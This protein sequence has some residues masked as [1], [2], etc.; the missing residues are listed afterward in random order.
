MVQW[1]CVA[2]VAPLQPSLTIAGRCCSL[3]GRVNVMHWNECEAGS[4]HQ[5]VPSI[6]VSLIVSVCRVCFRGGSWNAWQ[7]CDGA[8]KKKKSLFFVVVVVLRTLRAEIFACCTD[9]PS[10]S[11]NIWRA[12]RLARQ[13]RMCF[14]STVTMAK[15]SSSLSL[16]RCQSIGGSLSRKQPGT[17]VWAESPR[18]RGRR[19]VLEIE[20][21]KS[22]K[23]KQ[24]AR[25]RAR[26]QIGPHFTPSNRWPTGHAHQQNININN[27]AL[28]V[29][30]SF[31]KRASA[32]IASRVT[33]KSDVTAPSV[34]T[35]VTLLVC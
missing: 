19:S 25:P 7:R 22:L 18:W 23:K 21:Y 35:T 13:D 28:C 15:L 24:H 5:Q 3:S 12:R 1:F 27:T 4:L 14:R 17:E 31:R 33:K 26:R 11:E 10:V 20:S 9:D 32:V 30:F 2:H 8:K 29:E 16:P 34:C 6:T